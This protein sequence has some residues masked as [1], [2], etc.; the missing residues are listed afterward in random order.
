MNWLSRLWATVV[1]ETDALRAQLRST[2]NEL[3]NL[4]NEL[5]VARAYIGEL[6]Q[7]RLKYLAALEKVEA[8]S[9]TAKEALKAMKAPVKHEAPRKFVGAAS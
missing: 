1:G 8:V 3:L 5:R 9:H 6:E 2:Q 7:A 4:R